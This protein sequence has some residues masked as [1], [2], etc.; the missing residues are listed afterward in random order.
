M[1]EVVHFRRTWARVDLDAIVS[2]YGYLKKVAGKAR[3]CPVVKADA[4]GHGAVPVA[5]ALEERARADIFAVSSLDEAC[6]LRDAGIRAEIILLFGSEA[7]QLSLLSERRF[8][9][10]VSSLRVL[11]EMGEE[12]RRR[13]VLFGLHL[14]F[15][16]G[17]ARLGLTVGEAGEA[18]RIFRENPFLKLTGVSMHFA[19]AGESRE[20][21]A[22]QLERFRSVLSTFR[23]AGIDC[24]MIH[25][26]NS[27]ALLTEESARFDCARTGIALYGIRPEPDLDPEGILKP[28][29][30]WVSAVLQVRNLEEGVPVSYGGR[31]VTKRPSRIA[32]VSVGY[33]DGYRR[34]LGGAGE[35]I[36]RG[37]RLP[38][39]GRVC[40]DLIMAD[41]TDAP[42]VSEGDEVILIGKREGVEITAG[43]MASWED[44]IPYEILCSIGCRVPRH[45]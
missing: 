6:L 17:M 7:G 22:L 16:T 5:K 12:A 20:F 19:R 39:V 32:T 4:Y 37:R 34:S 31:F 25:A 18:G 3:I 11:R 9:P 24:G 10:V 23:D 41:V 13:E 1:S 21:T 28:A 8:T 14:N 30:E 36:I 35:V 42:G 33:A 40:M 26:A 29:L 45:Y 38:V 2:N 15:D 43:E 27:A 44:T